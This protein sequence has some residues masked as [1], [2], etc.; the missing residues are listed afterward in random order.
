M[1]CTKCGAQNS[2]GAAF[3]VSCG[4]S[5]NTTQAQYAQPQPAMYGGQQNAYAGYT[6]SKSKKGL[7]IGLI[8]GGVVL[9]AGIV[10]L[11]ILL[12]GGNAVSGIAGKWYDKAGLTGELDFK[13]NGTV[14]MKAMGQTFSAEYI[15][16]EKTGS[17]TI[18]IFGT[19]SD[20]Y[21]EGGVLNIEGTQ[22]T[23]EYVKQMDLSDIDFSDFDLSQFGLE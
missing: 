8:I 5:L 22:Y 14:D 15:Y 13:A 3:C 18:D 17:G 20:M 16:D 2:E 12:S 21:I 23:R 1:F 10:T 11:V 6:P 9:I 19:S 4:N 7:I